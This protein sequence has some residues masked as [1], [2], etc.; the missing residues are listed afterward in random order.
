LISTAPAFA[1]HDAEIATASA[2]VMASARYLQALFAELGASAA[3]ATTRSINDRGS[4]ACL[5][6]FV[7]RLLEIIKIGVTALARFDAR[8][9]AG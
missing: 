5:G 9:D 3:G 1:I 8:P 7:L 2:H 6:T 4:A